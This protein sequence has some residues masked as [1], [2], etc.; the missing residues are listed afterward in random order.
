MKFPQ[1]WLR[2]V[3]GPSPQIAESVHVVTRSDVQWGSPV[4]R[5]P[6]LPTPL[7]FNS[8]LPFTAGLRPRISKRR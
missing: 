2:L 6:S 8:E 1:H 4:F 7:Q 3:V 5:A